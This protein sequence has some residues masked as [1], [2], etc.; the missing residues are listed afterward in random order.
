MAENDQ[1]GDGAPSSIDP[2]LRGI[3]RAEAVDPPHHETLVGQAL[4]H[5]KI[6]ATLGA[7]GMG[8]VYASCS[9]F[10]SPLAHVHATLDLAR[11]LEA[12]SDIIGACK[13]YG[14]VLAR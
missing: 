12:T 2:F 3:A 4:S 11:A 14:E 7:G 8:V 9:R 1:E 10:N 13:A 6:E 5:F